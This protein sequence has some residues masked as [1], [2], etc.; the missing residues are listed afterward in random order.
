MKRSISTFFSSP[1]VLTLIILFIFIAMMIGDPFRFNEQ[2]PDVRW[3]EREK[4]VQLHLSIFKPPDSVSYTR[5]L[6]HWDSI[7]NI[8][9]REDY[10][11]YGRTEEYNTRFRV[12]GLFALF[13]ITGCNKCDVFE[14]L[15]NYN[16]E[17][18]DMKDEYYVAIKGF[19]MA[20]GRYF[21]RDRNTNFIIDGSFEETRKGGNT[22]TLLKRLR[23]YNRLE[24]MHVGNIYNVPFRYDYRNEMVWIP[25]SKRTY[26]VLNTVNIVTGIIIVLYML[27]LLI[28]I[29]YRI[30]R[31]IALGKA[32]DVRTIRLVDFLAYNFL[33]FPFVVF[34]YRYIVHLIASN[35]IT[36]DLRSTALQELF[37]RGVIMYIGLILFALGVALKKGFKLQREQDLTI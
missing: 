3:R 29:P 15:G 17:K 5:G 19:R 11:N 36:S 23:F 35:Y 20:Y 9:R 4:I 32:F 34:V 16:Y 18:S 30:I 26:G 24:E 1:L 31:N 37:S 22:D 28:N 21:L 13:K 33:L 8:Y 27:V 14:R 25:V 2:M 10:V 12:L 6:Q 7:I